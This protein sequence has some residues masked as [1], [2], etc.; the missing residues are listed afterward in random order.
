VPDL[1]WFTS[2]PPSLT[3][4]TALFESLEFKSYLKSSRLS[5]IKKAWRI[6][7]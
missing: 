6:A 1:Q 3:V 2:S 4:V 5:K 7:E